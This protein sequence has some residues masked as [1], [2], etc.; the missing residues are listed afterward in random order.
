MQGRIIDISMKKI[1]SQLGIGVLITY[2][3][4]GVNIAA[5]LLYT[6][7]MINQIGKNDYGLYTLVN[8]LI[9]MFLMDFGLSSATARYVAKYRSENKEEELEKFLSMVYK[10]YI[11]I[12]AVIMLILILVFFCIDI[13]YQNFTP[14]ELYKFKI[15][16]GIAGVYSVCSFPCIT[17]NGILN[18]YEKF[19]PLKLTDLFQKLCCVLFTIIA[20]CLN[21]GLYALVVVNAVS[22]L[23]ANIIKFFFV[24]QNIKVRRKRIE[25]AE[26]KAYFKAIFSFSLW[27][28]IW[29]LSQRLI[30]NITPTLLGIVVVNATAAISVFGIITTIEGYFHIITT[31][32][33]GMFLSRITR[34]LNHETGDEE[35]NRLAVKVGRFQFA[36][37][38]L[39]ILGF[40]LIGKEFIKLWVGE[41]FVEAYYGIILI[42]IPGAFYNTLQILHTTIVVKNL[43]KYQAYIQI[44][45]GIVNVIC[46]LILSHHMGALGAS[47]S[48]CVTYFLRLILTILFIKRK[49]CFDLKSFIK[50]CYIQ[51]GIPVVISFV[52]GFW[53]MSAIEGATWLSL[54]LKIILTVF[55]YII[56]ILLMGLSQDERKALYKKIN[57]DA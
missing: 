3:S 16:Y 15:I 28:T 35:L 27:S 22:G 23:V 40:C 14:E 29:A 9:T 43:V 17:F 4:I 46:S 34:I 57:K 45:V 37:N 32:I 36:L 55:I 38:G 47:I 51:T 21:G 7:W 48:I 30:F 33:N 6:P 49:L 42:V 10:L 53:V 54:I 12:D 44:V 13:I 18:A 8:S 31:A 20:L 39:L 25:V 2:F 5:G 56:S 19:I 1:K 41:N 11:L 52:I 24:N 50:K 26:R